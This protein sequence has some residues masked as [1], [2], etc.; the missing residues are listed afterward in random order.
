[1]LHAK[2]LHAKETGISYGHL[3]PRLVCAF[4]FSLSK[5]IQALWNQKGIVIYGWYRNVCCEACDFNKA[6][7]SEIGLKI[8]LFVRQNI[9]K[10]K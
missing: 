6:V 3:G 4:T 2:E 10:A 5:G 1:M 7:L 9:V 8:S